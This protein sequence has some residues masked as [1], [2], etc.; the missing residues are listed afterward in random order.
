[1]TDEEAL[2][3]YYGRRPQYLSGKLSKIGERRVE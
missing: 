1:M 3:K 2:I